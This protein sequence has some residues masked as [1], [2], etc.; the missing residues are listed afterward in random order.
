MASGCYRGLSEE[1]ID[2]K[3]EYTK[4]KDNRISLMR[5]ITKAHYERIAFLSQIKDA[6]IKILSKRKKT[7]LLY[8][9]IL[10]S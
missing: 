7:F 3:R 2:N 10:F 8:K 5:A 1:E 6:Q 9:K 4:K